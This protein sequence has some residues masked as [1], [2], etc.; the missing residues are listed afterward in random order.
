MV[1]HISIVEVDFNKA[2]I[3]IQI[4]EGT[5]IIQSITLWQKA[6]TV[7]CGYDWDVDRRLQP[8]VTAGIYLHKYYFIILKE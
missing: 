6:A 8:S 4:G 3:R 2:H 5:V 7:T 1:A